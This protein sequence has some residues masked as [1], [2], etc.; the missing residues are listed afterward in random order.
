MKENSILK[1]IRIL[2]F[3]NKKTI[4][5][6]A[7]S[8]SSM[9]HSY[10]ILPTIFASGQFVSLFLILKEVNG[11]FGPRVEETLFRPANIFLTASKSGK[12]TS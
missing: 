8:L 6:T 4:D 12:F 10:T 2:V 3:R 1:S 5:A 11:E 7:Q 9:T